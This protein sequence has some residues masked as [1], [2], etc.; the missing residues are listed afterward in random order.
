LDE[1][2]DIGEREGREPDRDRKPVGGRCVQKEKNGGKGQENER[3][4]DD[5][6]IG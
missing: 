1:K 4:E 2:V 3:E 5:I 6:E